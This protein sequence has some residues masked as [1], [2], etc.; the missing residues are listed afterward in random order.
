MNVGELTVIIDGDTYKLRADVDATKKTLKSFEDG[1]NTVSRRVALALTAAVT[2]AAVAFGAL[3]RNSLQV[4]DAQSK[5]AREFG[6]TTAGMQALTHA[7][8]LSDIEMGELGSSLRRLNQ[9]L[10]E[11][12]RTG[13]GPAADALARLNLRARDLLALDLDER[14]ALLADR[15][16]EAGFTTA[17]M[18]D[19]LRQLGLR[20]T[21]IVHL[22]ED[23]GDAIRDA[24][25]EVERFGVAVS[26]IDARRVEE[27]NDAVT[28]LKLAFQGL[29]NQFAVELAPKM[30]AAVDKITAF[31][32][33][34]DRLVP[35]VVSV[36]TAI[37]TTLAGFAL[38]KL[39]SVVPGVIAAI[40]TF[41]TALRAGTA[42]LISFQAALGPIGLALGLLAGA[43]VLLAGREGE[44]ERAARLHR[45]AIEELNRQIDEAVSSGPSHVA[46]LVAEKQAA[47]QAAEAELALVT[48][49]YEAAQAAMMAGPPGGIATPEFTEQLAQLEMMAGAYD[50]VMTRVAALRE[51]IVR[52]GLAGVEATAA[53]ADEADRILDEDQQRRLAELQQSLLTAEQL[54]MQSYGRRLEQIQEFLDAGII[55]E[56]QAS[57]FRR[58]A[59]EA[60]AATRA[61]AEAET[62]D[63]RLRDLQASLRTQEEEELYGYQRRLALLREFLEAGRITQ[64]EYAR[65]VEAATRQHQDALTQAEADG[66]KARQMGRDAVVGQW[67]GVLGQLSNLIKGEGE[68]QFRIA[69]ALSIAEAVINIAQG[70]TKAL[71]A[72]PPPLSY[73]MAAGVAA[74]GA[75]QIAA[76]RRAQPGSASSPPAPSG[77]GGSGGGGG[78]GGGDGG[79]GFGRAVNITLQGQG[80]F[81]R[82]VVRELIERLGSEVRDGAKLITVS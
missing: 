74:A 18:T 78:G 24:R 76:I 36:A 50:E 42:V 41:L 2:A 32:T 82:E 3:V 77:G 49:R 51:E 9:V 28:R 38:G 71:S 70:I 53:T 73:A 1:V 52:V 7:A 19:T 81:S 15:M 54:E 20:Q 80:G 17:Q 60:Y 34:S 39:L 79:G 61:E 16:R 22:F 5:M 65:L 11:S 40:G 10:A 26:D 14:F 75:I 37:G 31:I 57:S 68:K 8:N 29:G 48:A 12:A 62:E 4:I 30:Q 25:E 13:S 55:T 69:K 45:E 67:A 59:A 35:I 21:E 23:G 72:Y 44:A 63:T 66:N 64:Q 47:L 6:G 58:R 33:E 46:A 43:V 56:E 27:A